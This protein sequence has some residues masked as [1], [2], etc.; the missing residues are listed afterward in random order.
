MEEFME[1][2]EEVVLQQHLSRAREEDEELREMEEWMFSM[3]V[4]LEDIM[5]QTDMD[6]KLRKTLQEYSDLR[7][8]IEAK[9]Y[10]KLYLAGVRDGWKM[11]RELGMV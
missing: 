3:A 2:I 6:P 1:F 8:D 4:R 9:K 5:K 7:Y 11:M 10:L